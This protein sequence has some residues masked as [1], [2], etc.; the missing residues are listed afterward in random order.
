MGGLVAVLAGTASADITVTKARIGCLDIQL[1]GNLTPVVAAACDHHAS[2]SFK[3][4]TEDQYKHAGVTAKTRSF[5]TQ[6][7][8]ITYTCAPND[9]HTI[10]VPGD[11]W[12]QP[13]AQLTCTTPPPPPHTTTPDSIHVSRARI[14]C[15][16]IQTDAN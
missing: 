12:N 8:E 6:A 3:A 16:D 4:P 9:F 13:P 5:C 1:D 7:M 14:G 11:A 2:C 15:L 10:T